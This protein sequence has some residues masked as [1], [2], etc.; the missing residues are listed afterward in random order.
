MRTI[1][2]IMIKLKDR[3][4]NLREALFVWRYNQNDAWRQDIMP[5]TNIKI[6]YRLYMW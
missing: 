5:L 6:A 4:K 1:D 2:G 3:I